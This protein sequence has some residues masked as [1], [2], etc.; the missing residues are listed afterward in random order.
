MTTSSPEQ[1]QTVEYAR[2]S[3][4]VYQSLEKEVGR[5]VVTNLTTETEA[6]F[7]LGKQ[8][9]LQAVRNGFVVQAG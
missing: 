1:K 7:Q 5:I 4:A 6:A 3:P 8:F 2:F 9:V